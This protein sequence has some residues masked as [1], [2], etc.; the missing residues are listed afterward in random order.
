MEKIKLSLEISKDHPAYKWALN[1]SN[2][3]RAFGHVGTHIDCYTARPEAGEYKVGA[4]V[5]DC[6]EGMPDT[7]SLS[8]LDCAGKALVLYTSNLEKNGYGN[9]AYAAENTAFD[10]TALDAVLSRAPAFILIDSQGIGVHGEQHVSYDKR[11]ES[12]GCFVIEN[13]L[14]TKAV[15]ERLEA[16]EIKITG[17]GKTGRP[18][19]VFGL[20][21]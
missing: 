4:V 21:T 8:G 17:D 9:K 12:K 15:A 19:E 16:V 20:L 11:C 7:E 6:T 13:I 18:C 1:H 3:A 10:S 2:A 14:L 5:L